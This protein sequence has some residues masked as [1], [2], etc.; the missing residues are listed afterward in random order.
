M[1]LVLFE[2]AVDHL[3][4][5]YRIIRMNRGSALLVGVGGSGK[6]SL[7]KLSTYIS[8]FELKTIQVSSRY[9]VEDLKE[10]LKPCPSEFSGAKA[11]EWAAH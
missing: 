4:R 7:T 8:G 9:T 10:F 1:S 2:S 3:V 11:A 5:I 6:Q